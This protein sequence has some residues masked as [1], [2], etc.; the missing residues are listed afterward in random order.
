MPQLMFQKCICCC[1]CHMP[2]LPHTPSKLQL[3]TKS[4]GLNAEYTFRI[5]VNWLAKI[6]L[7]I[8]IKMLSS[9]TGNVFELG[10]QSKNSGSNNLLHNLFRNEIS[11]LSFQ[12]ST[13]TYP[14]YEDT[15]TC[16]YLKKKKTQKNN[17][18]QIPSLRSF[19]TVEA[20]KFF[21]AMKMF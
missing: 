14:H 3:W 9:H 10:I 1:V 11:E 7:V 5:T 15:V 17:T 20:Q 6:K 8:E 21:H 13:N 12:I 4:N 19:T 16:R 2:Y 18:T